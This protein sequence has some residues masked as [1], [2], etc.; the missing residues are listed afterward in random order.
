VAV[1]LLVTPANTPVLLGIPASAIFPATTGTNTPTQT[2]TVAGSDDAFSTTSP[3]IIAGTPTATWLTATTSGN[4]MTI[5]VSAAGQS[6]GVY[7]ATIPVSASAYSQA[8]DY[9][10]VMIVNGDG[11]A[12][13]NG[14]TST[15]GTVTVTENIPAG[16]ELVSMVGNGWSCP[17]AGNTCTR[18]DSLDAGASY[19]PITVTANVAN[20]APA[21]VINQV[22]ASGGGSLPA[23]ASDTTAIVLLPVLSVTKSHSGNFVQ[24]Q[25]G[26]AYAVIVANGAAAGP[27]SGTVTVTESVPSGLSLVSLGG[28]GWTCPVNGAT[29]YRI[30]SL[31]ASASY[32]TIT[33]TVNVARNAPA[34]AIN[35]VSVSGGGSLTAYATDTTTIV[36]PCA[37]TQ[38]G[39]AGVADV[40]RVINEALGKTQAVDDLNLDGVVNAVDVQIVINALLSLGCSL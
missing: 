20:D 3:P 12:S 34:S 22:S 5:G 16:L 14:V 9:P 1:S 10:V 6:T 37:L 17:T 26:A 39:S 7:A 8:I 19:P 18:N 2:V 31:P 29:C 13:G 15:N 30:D 27:T 33:V 36:S 25:T 28:S 40:Q 21:S 4:T 24:G 38:D 32:D 35:Q 11:G 23:T